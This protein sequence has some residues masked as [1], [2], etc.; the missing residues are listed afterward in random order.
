MG[1][2][3][4]GRSSELKGKLEENRKGREKRCASIMRSVGPSSFSHS[5]ASF[6][7]PDFVSS[8]FADRHDIRCTKKK[9]KKNQTNKQKKM[10]EVEKL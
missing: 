9:K 8:F 10:T 2:E 6:I 1:L 4:R 3:E 7:L 5:S